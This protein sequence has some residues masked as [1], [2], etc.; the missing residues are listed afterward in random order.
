MKSLV[1]IW[2]SL[3]LTSFCCTA[4][5]QSLDVDGPANISSNLVIGQEIASPL[6]ILSIFHPDANHPA[7]FTQ[8]QLGG[9]S[10]FEVTTQDGN[11]L[12]ATRILLRGNQNAA[13]V[14]FYSGSRG[15]EQQNLIIKGETGRVGIGISNPQSLLHVN[16]TIEIDNGLLQFSDGTEQTSAGQVS[17]LPVTNSVAIGIGSFE[18]ITATCPAGFRVTGG[19]WRQNLGAARPLVTELSAFENG[20]DGVNK[21]TVGVVNPTPAVIVI[22]VTADCAPVVPSL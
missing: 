19:G 21:W 11:G 13:D 22:D 14:E 4:S 12:Q 15:N 3:I 18:Q 5:A 2:L 8:A 9:V 17:S 10:S 20:P 6:T 7:G 16:G 1:Y